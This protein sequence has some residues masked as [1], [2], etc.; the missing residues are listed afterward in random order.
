[1]GSELKLSRFV[2]A[3]DIEDS[4][5]LFHSFRVDTVFL[6]KESRD[7]LDRLRLGVSPT[8][9]RKMFGTKSTKTLTDKY[10]LVD[11][12]YDE[13][14]ELQKCVRKDVSGTYFHTMYLLLAEPCNLDCGYCFFQDEMPVR[15]TGDRIMKESTAKNAL[16]LFSTWAEKKQPA[17]I[18]LYGGDPLINMR[19]LKFAISYTDQL[20]S[21][22]KLH[23]DTVVSIV[24]NGT[25]INEDFVEFLK[26]FGRRVSLGISLDGP[27]HIHDFWRK[28]K[29]K[30]GS[31]D[32]AI[33][34]YTLAKE[35]GLS[36]SISCTLAPNNLPE[37][38]A[39][40]DWLI[41][42]EP[43]GM[44]FNLLADT[45]K[46]HMDAKYA[47]DATNAMIRAFKRLSV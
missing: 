36:P 37:I 25:L 46:L 19:T 28:D 39:I 41:E 11:S 26:S 38:D 35:G 42:M 13:I 8:E 15:K 30:R 27:R 43:A 1:M 17:T 22:G 32:R 24:C 12:S 6:P 16:D 33:A 23:A 5:A 44:S 47:E 29:K 20:V 40:T 45:S 34:G 31:Y 7:L 14:A 9:A 21:E 2:H 10:F 18:I 4:L 3:F